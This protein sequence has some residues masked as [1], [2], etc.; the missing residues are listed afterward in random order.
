MNW[1]PPRRLQFMPFAGDLFERDLCGGRCD[2]PPLLRFDGWVA[3]LSSIFLASSRTFLASAS[4]TSG[5]RPKPIR[6]SLP[7]KRCLKR[8]DFAP[9]LLTNS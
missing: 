3:V 7:A 8:Q 6:F 2:K 5:Y 1:D 9:P 4:V